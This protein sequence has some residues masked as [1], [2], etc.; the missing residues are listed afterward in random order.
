MASRKPVTRVKY[1][2]AI[3]W[4]DEA[5]LQKA[6]RSLRRAFGPIDYE[7][8]EHLF[9]VTDYYEPEMG[10]GLHRCLVSFAELRAPEDIC[11]AKQTCNRIESELSAPRGRTVNLDIG[12]LDDSKVVLASLKA[13]GQKIHLGDGV[14]ADMISRFRSG[15]FV[16]FEWTFPDFKDGRYDEDLV[17]IRRA[18][19][20]Q[21][22]SLRLDQS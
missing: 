21:R 4:S 7:G 18:Y 17:T 6:Q 16:P 8:R 11:A 15:A 19:L 5:A 3:L 20:R 1:I 13:A 2:A 22:A 14:Y 12:Y 10:T 9:D